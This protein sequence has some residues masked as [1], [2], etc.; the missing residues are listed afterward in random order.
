[1]HSSDRIMIQALCDADA[2]ALYSVAYSGAL[3]VNLM[4]NSMESAWDPWVFDMIKEE[5]QNV[6]KIYSYPY[7]IFFII[8][9]IGVILVAP[10]FLYIMGGDG[11]VEAM[12]VIPPVVLAYVCSMFYSLYGALERYYKKQIVFPIFGSICAAANIG[13]NF[14]FIPKYGYIAAAYTTFFSCFLEMILHYFY[15]YKINK[16]NYYDTKFNLICLILCSLLS[17]LAIFLYKYSLIRYLFIGALVLSILIVLWI[18]RKWL[19]DY[20]KTIRGIKKLNEEVNEDEN[21]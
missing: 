5:K 3:L 21:N 20:L 6:I 8:I 11:Y 18:K 4:R 16:A 15:C 9:S 17:F 2:V 19:I 12:Y 14:L 13:L 7:I 10:E 1:M